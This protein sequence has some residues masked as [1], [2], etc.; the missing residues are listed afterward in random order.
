MMDEYSHDHL[1]FCFLNDKYGSNEVHWPSS[2]IRTVELLACFPE[3]A[4]VVL[5]N[6]SSRKAILP[7]DGIF[8]LQFNQRYEVP[9]PVPMVIQKQG[10]HI[11]Q[12][13]SKI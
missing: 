7:R 4:G 13:S 10:N 3:C 11:Y 1:E 8:H 2:Q 6:V 9:V 5:I 12:D